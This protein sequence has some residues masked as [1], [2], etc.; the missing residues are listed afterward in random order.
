M[1]QVSV[2]SAGLSV[3]YAARA[4][5][6]PPPGGSE[7]QSLAGEGSGGKKSDWHE[8][9]F[10][11]HTTI[12][13]DFWGHDINLSPSFRFFVMQLSFQHPSSRR[14]R[15]SACPE[16]WR[17]RRASYSIPAYEGSFFVEYC[18]SPINVQTKACWCVKVFARAR[19]ALGCDKCGKNGVEL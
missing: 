7:S 11:F 3:K 4:L 18:N 17:W 16:I 19:A 8:E 6:M 10:I 14:K 13:S 2:H 12:K 5:G 1:V 15:Q 9:Q